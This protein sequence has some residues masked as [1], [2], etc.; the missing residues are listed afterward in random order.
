MTNADI[1]TMVHTCSR[2]SGARARSNRRIGSVA[3]G[4]C[5]SCSSR[6][7]PGRTAIKTNKNKIAP[8]APAPNSTEKPVWRRLTK[9]CGSRYVWACVKCCPQKCT[10]TRSS[11]FGTFSHTTIVCHSMVLL[12]TPS[13]RPTSSGCAWYL[14]HSAL[15][16]RR[17]VGE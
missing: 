5:C 2:C 17:C 9:W 4:K 6:C 7:Q 16:F 10:C 14:P 8:P 3:S 15:R 13:I 12:N 1:Y 11:T